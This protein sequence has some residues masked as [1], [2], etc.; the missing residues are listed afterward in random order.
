MDTLSRRKGV[1]P[2]KNLTKRQKQL[3]HLINVQKQN[4]IPMVQRDLAEKLGI[5][6]ES[7]SK[8]LRRLRLRLDSQGEV[9]DMPGRRGQTPASVGTLMDGVV[10]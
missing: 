8:L 9:L 10:I 5:R 3:L 2:N 4:R 6:R 1:G 7:V